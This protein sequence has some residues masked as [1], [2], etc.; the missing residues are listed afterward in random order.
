MK[1]GL[2]V[3]ISAESTLRSAVFITA[4]LKLRLVLVTKIRKMLGLAAFSSAEFK[5]RFVVL[6]SAGL[7]LGLA[8]PMRN[9]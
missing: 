6:I 7:E 4:V 2:P 9:R 8:G 3:L 5:S 1:L